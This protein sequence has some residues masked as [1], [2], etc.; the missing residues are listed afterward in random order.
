MPSSGSNVSNTSDNLWL[1]NP[2]VYLENCLSISHLLCIY[3]GI[4]YNIFVMTIVLFCRRF[5]SPRNFTWL[6]IGFSN[7]LILVYYLT[8]SLAVSLESSVAG[9][10]CDLLFGLPQL[11]LVLN[12]SLSLL[13]RY[14]SI[15]YSKWHKRRI[16]NNCWIIP[17][18]QLALFFVLF[19]ISKGHHI[20][21]FASLQWPPI[22]SDINQVITVLLFGV[23]ICVA[24]Q[25]ALWTI[26]NQNYPE[27][28]SVA[29]VEIALQP[30]E[31]NG[32]EEESPSE[33]IGRTQ[34]PFVR[35]GGERIS[36]L[37]LEAARSVNINGLLMALFVVPPLLGLVALARCRS[38]MSLSLECAHLVAMSV[39][40]REFVPTYCSFV[41]PTSF[42]SLNRDIRTFVK[43]C[44][45]IGHLFSKPRN[46]T[47]VS[48]DLFS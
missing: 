19:L 30:L 45:L 43:D 17:P 4:P 20:F 22:Q 6:G 28:P 21:G 37:D 36:R 14:L 3:L 15:K 25:A 9:K 7:V 29:P 10:I 24:F 47:F 41:S 2:S 27:L 33:E 16:T 13:E 5:R 23:G 31:S 35:I 1:L 12:H 44:K 42:L 11:S 32:M 26:S 8:E 46:H 38:A 40:L 18:V 39:Y 34:S 48:E